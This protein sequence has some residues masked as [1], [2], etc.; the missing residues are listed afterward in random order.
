MPK[1]AWF[2]IKNFTH[3]VKTVVKSCSLLIY[4]LQ[5]STI[6]CYNFTFIRYK[7][8]KQLQSI[9]NPNKSLRTIMHFMLHCI[10]SLYVNKKNIT[11]QNTYPEAE[12]I[13][14]YHRHS[15]THQMIE[16]ARAGEHKICKEISHHW[17]VVDNLDGSETPSLIHGVCSNS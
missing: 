4:L 16:T 7:I 11:Y 10:Y 8:K 12:Q 13:L 14:C 17:L 2:C 5:F 15:V 6:F 9:F 1:I 3:R